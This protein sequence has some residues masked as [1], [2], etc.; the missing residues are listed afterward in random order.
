MAGGQL[1]EAVQLYAGELLEG[2]YD[3]WLAETSGWRT[4]AS[5]SRGSTPTR[6][7]RSRLQEH[8]LRWPEAIRCAERL[9]ALD[10]VR[11]ESHRLLAPACGARRV[12]PGGATG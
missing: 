12:T 10:P 11:E 9:V 8:D 2:R 5:G 7:S 6:S 1:E 4:N 3:E